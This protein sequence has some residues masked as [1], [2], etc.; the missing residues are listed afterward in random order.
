MT[1]DSWLLPLTVVIGILAYLS[2]SPDPRLW[3]YAQWVQ[4]VA[5]T[6]AVIAAQLGTSPLRG[7]PKE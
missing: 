6:L 3:T 4:F 1:R 7:K 5:A 2:Q